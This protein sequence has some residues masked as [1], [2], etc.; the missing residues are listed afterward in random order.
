MK[1]IKIFSFFAGAGFLD[2]GFEKARGFDVVFVNEFSRTFN[3]IY[4]YARENMGIRGPRLGHHVCSI[5]D[6]DTP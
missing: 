2:L 4:Q 3:N 5:E 6:L 1:R